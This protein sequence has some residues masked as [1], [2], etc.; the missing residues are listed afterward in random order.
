MHLYVI[1]TPIGNLGDVSRRAQEML[2]AV[3][4]I[5]AED[6]RRVGLLLQSLGVGKKELWSY[7]DHNE[8]ERVAAI[9]QRLKQGS[10]V[11]LVSD[12][13]TPLI[14]DPGYR[15]VVACHEAGIP[16]IAVPGP[17]AVVAALSI[18][19]LP[20]DRFRFEGFLPPKGAKR[21]RRVKQILGSDVTS[22]LFES[23]HKIKKLMQEIS[24]LEADRLVVICR[25]LTKIHEEVLRGSALSLFKEIEQRGGLKGEMVVLLGPKKKAGRALVDGAEE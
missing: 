11:A 6:T 22:I 24:D 17:S 12:A 1:A 18:S 16:V 13:G 15:I 20:P 8:R 14:S 25:E 7:H 23:T 10:K 9:I 3:D 2:A 4:L 5:L 19:G 21:S